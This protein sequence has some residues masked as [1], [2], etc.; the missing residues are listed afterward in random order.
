MLLTKLF[1]NLTLSE[2]EKVKEA[3]ASPFFN[4]NEKFLQIFLFLEGYKHE[5]NDT[6]TLK[7]NLH[8]HLFGKTVYDDLVIR[9]LLSKFLLLLENIISVLQMQQNELES[10]LYYLSWLNK[11]GMGK[12]FG[13]EIGKLTSTIETTDEKNGDTYY[14]QYK[15]VLAQQEY[16][17]Q[18]EIRYD[19]QQLQQ[20]SDSFDKYAI[21]NKLKI[22]CT[23]YSL[24]T[25]YK[26]TFQVGM[27]DDVSHYIEQNN[28][29]NETLVKLYYL[30][31][32]T[33]RN[34]S[35]PK[36]FD[37]LKQNLTEEKLA[38]GK[39]EL[40]DLFILAQNYCIRK[41]NG[42]KE[43]YFQQLFELYQASLRLELV[44]H[45]KVQFPPAFKNIV[46][47]ALR[48]K[49]FDWL[50]EFIKTHTSYIQLEYR[51]DYLNYNLAR[52]YF[53]QQNF[54]AAQDHLNKLG[55]KDIFVALS[56]RVLLAKTY[57]ELGLDELLYAHLDS[58]KQFLNRKDII[59]N[60]ETH[61]RNIKYIRR[62]L[63]LN[64]YDKKRKQILKEQ[65]ENEPALTER[66]WLLEKMEEL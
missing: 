45:D 22:A 50:E 53:E 4:K 34:E 33:L 37:Q 27:I 2:K 15:L 12:R 61:L 10:E 29:L 31:L 41:V 5:L 42:G 62:L 11:N 47:V 6:L 48:L 35:K 25:V 40:Q 58:L 44:Q 32:Q 30:G 52:V 1:E 14:Q 63:N 57:Y 59:A 54:E 36:F 3:L 51:D 16:A 13:Q 18:H 24:Q 46:S 38:I 7:Q 39:D 8:K 43:A 19:N 20:L 9:H 55:Y 66:K 60:R 21:I 56:A 65:I 64:I 17:T 26:T 49:S 23:A 28:F